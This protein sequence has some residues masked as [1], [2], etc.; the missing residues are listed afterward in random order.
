MSKRK[1]IDRLRWYYPLE[2]THA[3]LTFPGMLVYVILNN[4]LSSVL[5]LAYGLL[6]CIFILI[7]GQH[8]WKLKLYRLT[9][10]PFDQEYHI[11]L[12]KKAKAINRILILI[13]PIS[14][15]FQL[16]LDNWTYRP[17][18]LFLGALAANLFAVLE[19]V[20]YYHIQLMIDNY[21]DLSYLIKNQRFKIASLAK[22]LQDGEI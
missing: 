19:H 7:Q 18:M 3:F 22:D 20:N 6:V 13:I 1:L 4:S 17:D 21:A 12:F 9:D 2:R 16:Y 8:Y 14:F 5:F 10:K 11:R 15:G